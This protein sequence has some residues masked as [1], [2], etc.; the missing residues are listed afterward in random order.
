MD[1][2]TWI[3][4]QRHFRRIAVGLLF[5]LT[6]MGSFV[7]CVTNSYFYGGN[8]YST[9]VAALKVQQAE[10]DAVLAQIAPAATKID[11]DV[12]VVLPSEVRIKKLGI[13]YTLGAAAMSENATDYLVQSS[14]LSYE[15]MAKALQ[16][17]DAFKKVDVQN[18]NEPS[19]FLTSGYDFIVYL[20]LIDANRTEWCVKALPSQ[21]V[22]GVSLDY[23]ANL[24]IERTNAWLKDITRVI[25]EESS[26]SKKL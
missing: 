4:V 25:Q 24:G 15:F 21:Q 13:R 17:Y 16:Q 9:P 19:G 10:L 11:S 12:L 22:R 14:C 18:S 8:K 20:D 2:M 7:G 5:V 3:I 23:S 1:M 26:Q 6:C